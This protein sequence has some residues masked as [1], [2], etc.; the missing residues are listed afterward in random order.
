MFG[1]PQRP[2]DGGKEAPLKLNSPLHSPFL[3]MKRVAFG[4]P[5]ESAHPVVNSLICTLHAWPAGLHLSLTHDLTL[6][7]IREFALPLE[8]PALR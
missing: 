7:Y 1:S 2:R 5:N 8:P 4:D 3:V 6:S